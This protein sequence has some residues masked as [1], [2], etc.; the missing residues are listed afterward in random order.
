MFTPEGGSA[1][2]V[3]V[4]AQKTE[5][6]YALEAAVPW[7]L[8]ARLAKAPDL[9]PGS[10][11]PLNF[12][13]GISDTDGPDSA[14]E[15]LMTILTTPWGHV[16]TGSWWRP[17]RPS[18]G[19]PPA[20]VRGVDLAKGAKLRRGRSSR[21]ASKRRRAPK[22]K[23]GV[24]VLKAR[25]DT[26]RAAG[27]NSGMRLLLN[28]Q[29]VDPRRLLNRQRAEAPRGGQTMNSRAGDNFNVCY[30]PDFDAPDR[31]PS[32][33]LRSGAKLCLFELRVSDLL[34]AGDNV[35]VIENMRNAGDQPPAGRGR[36]PPGD[37]S[38]GPAESE[39]AGPHRPAGDGRAGA[40][41]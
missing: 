33:A 8:V 11:M 30:A 12:E 25:L 29:I 20:V 14:Q 26:P 21:F 27:W 40:R 36:R 31:H 38:A 16:P 7:A 18:D 4:A 2:G 9:K 17:W 41:A 37:S 19:K 5:K 3:L 39:A 13:V 32:Y 23:E 34:R 1:E 15:K 10:G 28:G 22:G 35:L 6:G 24:L